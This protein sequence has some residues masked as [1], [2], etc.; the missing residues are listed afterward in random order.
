MDVSLQLSALQLEGYYVTEL[1]YKV[2]PLPGDPQ[3]HMQGG[4]GVQHNGIYDAEPLTI[5]V[6]AAAMQHPQELHRWQHVL[7]ISSQPPPDRK[8]PYDFQITLVGYF[9]VSEQVPLERREAFVKI[10]AAS[11]LY[12][13]A[14]EL[15]ATVTGR[16]PLPCVVLPTAVFLITPEHRQLPERKAKAQTTGKKTAKKVTK[17]GTTKKTGG[18]KQQR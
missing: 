9:T 16:G 12:S 8:Y 11:I 4:I 1:T 18:K 7:T 10:N 14:R 6:Q 3:F 2:R 15:L 5:N 17:K 13:A